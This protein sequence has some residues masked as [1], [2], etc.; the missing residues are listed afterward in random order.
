MR[1]CVIARSNSRRQ[2]GQPSQAERSPSA[3]PPAQIHWYAF[4]G[5]L[6]CLANF[7]GYLYYQVK[8]SHTDKVPHATPSLGHPAL[9]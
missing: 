7:V 5:M 6:I 3:R 9:P 4:V 1:A 2:A 8:T